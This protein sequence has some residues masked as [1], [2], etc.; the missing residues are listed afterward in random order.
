[1]AKEC[2][3]RLP[4]R[5][6]GVKAHLFDWDGNGAQSLE[7]GYNVVAKRCADFG[8]FP[9]RSQIIRH[10]GDWRGAIKHG[11]PERLLDEYIVGVKPMF[12][13]ALVTAPLYPG[14]REVLATL[15]EQRKRIA[16]ITSGLRD[17][18]R[19]S[20][21]FHGLHEFVESLVAAEDVLRHKPYPDP[22]HEALGELG[23]GADEAVMYGDSYAKDIAAARAAGTDAVLFYPPEHHEIYGYSEDVLSTVPVITSWHQVLDRLQ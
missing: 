8:L 14:F 23:V 2:A 18:I 13:D 22:I 11:L 3:S 6:G 15:W 10:Y 7:A 16:I 12:H 9:A 20:L 17:T 19:A 5:L 4:L 21:E 1:M